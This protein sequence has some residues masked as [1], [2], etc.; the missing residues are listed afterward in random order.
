MTQDSTIA[1]E[2]VTVSPLDDCPFIIQYMK[3]YSFDGETHTDLMVGEAIDWDIPYDPRDDDVDEETWRVCNYGG[4]DGVLNL[5]YQQGYEATWDD[6]SVDEDCQSNFDRFGGNAFVESYFGGAFASGGPDGG[7]VGENEGIQNDDG[8]I[9]GLFYQE[10]MKTG[11][12]ATDSVEDLHSAMCFE[13][14]L[15]L[16]ATDY[17]EVVTVLATVHEGTLAELKAN[18]TAGKAWYT[19]NGGMA[20]FADLDGTGGI[21]LCQGCCEVM[22]DLND[23]G[24]LS[25]SDI[26]YFVNWMWKG[27]PDPSCLDEVDVNG[28]LSGSVGDIIYI[29]N[30]L[31]KGGP[32]PVPCH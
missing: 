18:I 24:V 16:G 28:D 3:V 23:D 21:D 26:I 19:A 4:F 7:A 10:M 32:A 6:D 9:Q 15:D 30:Y 14:N 27:G 12:T 17:Y 25:M 11:L 22:G 20:I 8:F 13:N 31:W 1:F 2:K 5:L 29:V